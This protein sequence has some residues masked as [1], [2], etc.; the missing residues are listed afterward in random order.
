V[1]RLEKG[2]DRKKEDE[3]NEE[4]SEIR[5]PTAPV[6]LKGKRAEQGGCLKIPQTSGVRVCPDP[7]SS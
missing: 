5:L 6:Y 1:E 2:K 4:R 3:K 7:L